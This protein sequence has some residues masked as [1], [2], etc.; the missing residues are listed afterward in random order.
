MEDRIAGVLLAARSLIPFS[1]KRIA[2]AL[3]LQRG[4]SPRPVLTSSGEKWR[5]GGDGSSLPGYGYWGDGD[6]DEAG[7][8]RRRRCARRLRRTLLGLLALALG[9]AVV[10]FVWCTLTHSRRS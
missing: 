7:S 1:S 6:G 4:K 9:W 8:P 5:G 2:A 10:H 3:D